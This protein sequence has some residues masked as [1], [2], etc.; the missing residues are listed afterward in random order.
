MSATLNAAVHLGKAQLT[1]KQLFDVSQ[2]LITDQKEIQGVAK[3]GRYIQHLAKDNFVERQS[4]PQFKEAY[5]PQSSRNRFH[6]AFKKRRRIV[7]RQLFVVSEE[8]RKFRFFSTSSEFITTT[9]SIQAA[10][11]VL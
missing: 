7:S 11:R 6:R 10:G 8:I 9:F 2:K 3:I 4:S 1:V 5:R